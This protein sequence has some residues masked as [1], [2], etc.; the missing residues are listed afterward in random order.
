[1]N[2]LV[3]KTLNGDYATLTDASGEEIIVAMALLP[4]DIDVGTRLIYDGAEFK[5]E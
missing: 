5:N 3:V 2:V 1:M 4:F